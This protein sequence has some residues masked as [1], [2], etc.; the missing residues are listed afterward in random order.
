MSLS[1]RIAAL[2]RTMAG[3]NELTEIVIE[4][5]LPDTTPFATLLPDGDEISAGKRETQ[6]NFE[7]RVRLAAK[8][9]SAGFL[10][11]G[12]LPSDGQGISL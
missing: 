6:A 3:Q 11:F 2:E 5:G 8:E 1:S 7:R 4:G 9:Q 10:I 12:G